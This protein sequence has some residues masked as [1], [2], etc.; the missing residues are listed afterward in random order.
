MGLAGKHPNK[1]TTLYS[2]TLVLKCYV[3]QI[4]I[5]TELFSSVNGKI[6]IKKAWAVLMAEFC[7]VNIEASLSGLELYD[8]GVN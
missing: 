2:E 1:R 8:M 6:L 4:Y 7:V 3:D 5:V